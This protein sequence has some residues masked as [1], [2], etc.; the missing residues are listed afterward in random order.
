[1]SS[2]PGHTAIDLS[3]CGLYPAPKF[4]GSSSVPGPNALT[5]ALSIWDWRLRSQAGGS[6]PHVARIPWVLCQRPESRF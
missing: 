4:P 2:K 3:P 1:M 6:E 5:I